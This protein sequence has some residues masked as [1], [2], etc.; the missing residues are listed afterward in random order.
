MLVLLS[1]INREHTNATT[2]FQRIPVSVQHI[3]FQRI[4]VIDIDRRLV[5]TQK[6]ILNN[7]FIRCELS[8]RKRFFPFLSVG[9]NLFFLLR[10]AARRFLPR[11]AFFDRTRYCPAVTFRLPPF[12]LFTATAA[13]ITGFHRG[14]SRFTACCGPGNRLPGAGWRIPPGTE[15]PPVA[16]PP[17]FPV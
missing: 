8:R 16:P 12:I 5:L 17:H 10:F 1:F 11:R 4:D 13:V 3:W 6:V 9:Y 7:N 14:G 15:R 2:T